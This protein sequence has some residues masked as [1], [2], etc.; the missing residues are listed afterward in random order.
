ME[1]D[2]CFGTFVPTGAVH[3]LGM[4]TYTTLLHDNNSFLQNIATIPVGDFQ[5][6]T[7]D[8][9]FSIDSNNNIDQTTIN[10]MI[11]E[12]PWC[13]NVERT[14]TTNKVLIVT[15]KVQLSAAQEWMDNFLPALYEQ[16]VDDKIYVMTLKHLTLQHLDKLNI[17]SA[18]WSYTEKLKQCTTSA[19]M[20]QNLTQFE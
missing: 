16:H 1:L 18:T 9:P 4:E 7:L 5:H 3:L 15:M 14:T 6:K 17:T 20:A 12:Q 19:T 13:L 8:I 11:L 10:D 2:P